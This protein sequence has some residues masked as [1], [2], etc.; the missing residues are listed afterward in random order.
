MAIG[1]RDNTFP[2]MISSI[3]DK[4]CED[5]GSFCSHKFLSMKKRRIS[6]ILNLANPGEQYLQDSE[7][8]HAFLI[9]F[10]LI[11]LC[12]ARGLRRSFWIDMS[13]RQVIL[14]VLSDTTPDSRVR[15]MA[16]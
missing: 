4:S 10:I 11:K 6:R 1:L 14:I 16:A 7:G 2:L 9:L 12:Y 13:T 3:L 5:K 8:K 15:G